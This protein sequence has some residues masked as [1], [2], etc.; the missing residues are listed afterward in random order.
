MVGLTYRD[1]IAILQIA[2]FAPALIA[3]IFLCIRHGL[4]KAGGSLLL[5]TFT[6]TRLVGA[7]C[8]LANETWPSRG[9]VTAELICLYIGL[10]PLTIVCWGVLG[11]V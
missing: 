11:R 7:A 5:V 3:A 9:L 10:S 2:V 4:S 8:Q 1:G 6:I